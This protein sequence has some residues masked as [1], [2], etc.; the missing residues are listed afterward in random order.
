MEHENTKITINEVYYVG[1]DDREIVK[2]TVQDC[3]LTG[4]FNCGSSHGDLN[5]KGLSHS[6][7]APFWSTR[8]RQRKMFHCIVFVSTIGVVDFV[9]SD[10]AYSVTY[11]IDITYN[12]RTAHQFGTRQN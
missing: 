3:C 4:L 5:F 12:I 6:S 8:P 2:D 11:L 9:I 7:V 1:H 10:F